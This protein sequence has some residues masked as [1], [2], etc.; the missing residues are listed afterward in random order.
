MDLT[1]SLSSHASDNAQLTPPE[2]L[3]AES[4]E[5]ARERA[6][7]QDFEKH[8]VI[9]NPSVPNTGHIWGIDSAKVRLNSAGS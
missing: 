8:L 3:E 6:L 9:V 7:V 1:D 4:Q 2:I 5:Q